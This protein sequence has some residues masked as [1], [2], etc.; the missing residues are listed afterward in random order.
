V[1]FGFADITKQGVWARR[2]QM[3]SQFVVV[4]TDN[5]MAS[6]EL[7]AS[8]MAMAAHTRFI[9]VRKMPQNCSKPDVT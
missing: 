8:L 4:T 1:I 7:L 5:G 3:A 2:S 6:I 9:V